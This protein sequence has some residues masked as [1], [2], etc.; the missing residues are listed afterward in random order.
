MT[1]KCSD[2]KWNVSFA[3]LYGVSEKAEQEFKKQ[4]AATGCCW[5]Q[6]PVEI[7]EK[8]ECAYMEAATDKE[9]DDGKKQHDGK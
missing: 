1:C 2:C 3:C 9:Q 4:L 5:Y 7:N 6:P 8:G